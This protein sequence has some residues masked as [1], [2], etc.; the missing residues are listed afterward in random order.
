MGHPHGGIVAIIGA[1]PYGLSIAAYLQVAGIEFRIFGSPM[2]RWLAQMPKGMFLKSE[3]CGSNLSDPTGY[4]SL[5]QYCIEQGLPYGA[6]GAPVSREIFVRYALSFQ[7]NLV[8]NVEDVTVTAVERSC[9]GLELRLSSNETLNVG[10]VI[11]A[12]G[13]EHTAY[14]PP[15]LAKLPNELRSHSSDHHDLSHFKGKDITVIGGGQAAHETAA[16]LCEG[17]ASVRLLVREPSLVWNPAPNM[18]ARSIYK[19]LRYPRTGLGEGLSYWMYCNMPRLFHHLPRQTRIVKATTVL[20]PAGAFWLKSRVIDRLPIL[21]G[22]FVCGAEARGNHA[23]LQVMDKGQLRDIM[24]DHVIAATGYRFDLRR[25]PFLSENLKSQLRH[26]EQLPKL[27]PNFESSVPGLYFTGLASTYAFG[28]SMRF[29]IGTSYTAQ[30][31]S[32]HIAAGRSS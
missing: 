32:N 12:T 28:P 7:R 26:E 30:R 25:L 15:G 9:K 11:L 18:S 3:G 29:L 13:M 4:H 2:H 22:H 21:F 1:G 19:R 14:L 23:V 16:L 27:S 6:W 8:R 24:T 5:A 20:G 31:I 17:G 10:K